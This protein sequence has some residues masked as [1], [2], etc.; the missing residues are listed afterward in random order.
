MPARDESASLA[1][2]IRKHVLDAY[3]EPARRSGVRRVRV[4][5]GDVAKEMALGNRRMPAI[6]QALASERKFQKPNS[7][8]LVHTVAPAS[9]QSSTVVYEYELTN[10]KEAPAG[11]KRALELFDSL[12]GAFKDA[13][14]EY[15]GGEEFL[16]K[17]R[18]S[19]EE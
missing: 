1:D 11:N 14:A 12:R 10:A 3:I 15:G 18:A 9:G 16:R 19:W 4:R 17:E 13:F 6:C 5:T 7:L 2:Q 8:R